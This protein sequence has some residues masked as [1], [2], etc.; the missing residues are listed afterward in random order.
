MEQLLF[1]KEISKAL[2]SKGY[3]ISLTEN[4]PAIL[5]NINDSNN[6]YVGYISRDGQLSAVSDV[7]DNLRNI[8]RSV[9]EYTDRFLKASNIKSPS[10]N[11]YRL[12]LEY[13]GIALGCSINENNTQFATWRSD[14]DGDLN[15]GNYFGDHY[16]RAKNDFAERS[17]LSEKPQFSE[18]EL[19][20]IYS[21]LVFSGKTGDLDFENLKEVEQLKD[22]ITHLIPTLKE[23]EDEELDMDIE[24]S[25]PL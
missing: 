13:N 17:G 3:T 18:T 11:H 21:S 2:K 5:A 19:K 20:I 16:E 25:Y 10:L 1:Y 22:K 6:R 12:L 8:V 14:N 23:L 24:P 7:F 15:W 4:D 9:K